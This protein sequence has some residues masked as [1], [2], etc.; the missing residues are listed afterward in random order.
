[1]F[2][3]YE[4]TSTRLTEE[5]TRAFRLLHS[6]EAGSA[7]ELRGLLV[8]SIAKRYG[9]IKTSLDRFSGSQLQE[10]VEQQEEEEEEEEEEQE[11]QEE[12]KEEEQ[13]EQEEE[14]E[15]VPWEASRGY[16]MDSAGN[17][18]GDKDE[19]PRI[20]I[21]DEGHNDGNVCKVFTLI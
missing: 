21:P 13:E 12:Q 10:V 20:S 9:S 6:T 19:V 16:F 2:S 1:M 15:E 5:F 17:D 18:V 11:E 7:E 8:A 3:H 14:E 4:A